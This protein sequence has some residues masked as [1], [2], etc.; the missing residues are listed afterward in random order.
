[1]LVAQDAP[2]VTGMVRA[3]DFAT[4]RLQEIRTM[5]SAIVNARY[6]RRKKIATRC[7]IDP[8]FI[9][10]ALT[11][12]TFQALPREMRRRAAS[13]DLKRLPAHLRE[14]AAKEV[15]QTEI[16]SFLQN[17]SLSLSHT[18]AGLDGKGATR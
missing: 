4:A 5:Q 2:N 10:K 18:L 11:A 13:H 12:L 6:Q 3:E 7:C 1:M 15:R 8:R 17:I 16:D 9:S 14:K